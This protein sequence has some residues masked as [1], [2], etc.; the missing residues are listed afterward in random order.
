MQ[1]PLGYC[2]ANYVL[3]WV[4]WIV[5]GNLFHASF[6]EAK[7]SVKIYPQMQIVSCEARS[8]DS[9]PLSILL[10]TIGYA[11]LSSI[12]DLVAC[13]T[14]ENLLHC[15]TNS[16]FH[17]WD[18][19]T[20]PFII[21]WIQHPPTT[22]NLHRTSLSGRQMNGNAFRSSCPCCLKQSNPPQKKSVSHG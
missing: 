2:L 1:L 19:T 13:L 3:D 4:E 9:S 22:W 16:S 20:S 15:R 8:L 17:F 11:S 10:F 12:F 6:S 18:P 7:D 14:P 5:L 21:P